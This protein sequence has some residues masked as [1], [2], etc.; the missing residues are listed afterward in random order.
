ME[1]VVEIDG[2]IGDRA[3]VDGDKGNG[4][5]VD[6]GDVGFLEA[7]VGGGAKE[8]AADAEI[9]ECDIGDIDWRGENRGVCCD[10]G[11]FPERC[12]SEN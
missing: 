6:G 3:V 12:E 5:G 11:W 4:D 1:V 7:V 10:E 8:D 2:T 9:A